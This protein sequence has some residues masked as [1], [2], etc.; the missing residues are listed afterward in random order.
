MKTKPVEIL[1]TER[2][3][4]VK[5]ILKDVLYNS[6]AQAILKTWYTPY[7]LLKCFWIVCLLATFSFSSYVIIETL[8]SFF[9]YEVFTS[10]KTIFETPTLFPKVTI[11]N[12]NLITSRYAY[13]LLVNSNMTLEEMQFNM[14]YKFN[15]TEIELLQHSF[16][17]VLVDCTFNNQNCTYLDFIKEY[18]QNLGLCY[19]F[20]SGFNQKGKPVKL[21]ETMRAGSLYGLKITLYANFYEHLR[22]FNK[23]VG[24]IIKV[25]NSSYLDTKD[26]VEIA[27]GFKTNIKVDR[28]FEK[29]LPKPYS[30]CEVDVD[31]YMQINSYLVQLIAN[32][33]Y[34]YTQ[35]LCFHLCF[36]K[37]VIDTCQCGNPNDYHFFDVEPCKSL[38]CIKAVISEYMNYNIFQKNCLSSCPL[39]CNRTEYKTFINTIQ[40][41]GEPSVD[42]IK[43][44]SQLVADFVTLPINADTAKESFARLYV[45]Y[46]PL[47]YTISTD[48][49]NMNRFSLIASIGGTFS[50][51][52]G[53]SAMSLFEIIAVLIEV[54][55]V[56][57][58]K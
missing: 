36:Q 14:N 25:S 6:S 55:F 7:R 53:V 47:S 44:N 9:S 11:C 30:N 17:D 1:K 50:L 28:T 34:E 43:K 8:I 29:I 3:E 58:K 27:A 20:N 2:S 54:Y 12:K 4:V 46:D 35:Q 32:S 37:S 13:E 24:F 18:D 49:P 40:L 5:K 15:D 51:F 41:V 52:L 10:T 38:N 23:Y 57:K 48:Y 26:G 22:R 45:F 21:R 33:T 56:R 42:K 16:R 31:S 19:V 39:Q